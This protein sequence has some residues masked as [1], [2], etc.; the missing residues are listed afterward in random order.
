M[1]GERKANDVCV[2]PDSNKM[3]VKALSANGG[4]VFDM[5]GARG[6]WDGEEG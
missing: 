1:I 5:S 6:Y 3:A 2:Y 4:A